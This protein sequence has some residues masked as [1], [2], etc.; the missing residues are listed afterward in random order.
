MKLLH[1]LQLL[2]GFCPIFP[3]SF[4]SFTFHRAIQH[5]CPSLATHTPTSLIP[6]PH[7]LLLILITHPPPHHQAQ[8]WVLGTLLLHIVQLVQV[9]GRTHWCLIHHHQVGWMQIKALCVL[10]SLYLIQQLA[11]TVLLPL[12]LPLH[13]PHPQDHPHGRLL[14]NTRFQSSVC[15]IVTAFP[16]STILQILHPLLLVMTPRQVFHF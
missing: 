7:T 4:Y 6:H 1:I 10:G 5:T 3:L 8:P 13:K 2:Y 14:L 11:E 12:T 15:K 16:C 9:L